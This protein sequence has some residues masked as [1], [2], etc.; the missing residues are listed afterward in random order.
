MPFLLRVELPDV[1]G[2]LGRLAT[3]IGE[4]GGDIEAIEIVEKRARRARPST[5]CSSRSR[6]ARCP[7]RSCRPATP[8]TASQVL[9]ISRYAAGGN[10][11]LDL[12]A[13]EDLTAHPRTHSTGWSTCC[14]S[15]SAPTGAP[16]CTATAGVVH[17]TGGAPDDVAVGRARP[18]RAARGRGRDDDLSPRARST[19]TRSWSSAAAAAPSSSTPSSP[20]SATSPAG[21][22]DL[23]ARPPSPADAADGY[24]TERIRVTKTEPRML[25]PNAT[26]Y[27]AK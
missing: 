19:T 22:L 18:G 17:A 16:G 9:W 6:P 5:T 24:G 14:R 23:R 20:A 1:P 2:S 21:D 4:A 15:C 8:S 10:V 27:T 26:A 3:A 11:F 12:E 7:T 25:T 13:V